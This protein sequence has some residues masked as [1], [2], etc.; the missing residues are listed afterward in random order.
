[1][2][3]AVIIACVVFFGLL[4]TWAGLRFWVWILKRRVNRLRAYNQSLQERL[5]TMRAKRYRI[6]SYPDELEEIYEEA[7]IYQEEIKN[8]SCQM[9]EAAT[10]GDQKQ[11]KIHYLRGLAVF[12]QWEATL[13]KANE[14]MAEWDADEQK[15][16]DMLNEA[17]K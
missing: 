17:K 1:M 6:E 13:A 3:H 9:V 4:G 8:E 10:S 7:A 12:E 16:K 15:L 5:D 2:S 14:K 11:A